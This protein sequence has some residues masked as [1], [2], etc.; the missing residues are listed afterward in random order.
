[1]YILNEYDKALKDILELGDDNP[2]RTGIVCRSLTGVQCSY[3]ISTHF[4]IPTKRRYAYKS[5]FAELLWMLSGSTNVN[6]LERMGSK[7]WSA[8]KD[9]EFEK[10]NGYND[11][12]LGPLYSFQMRHQGGDYNLRDSNP[13]GFDQIQYLVDELRN[14][15]HSRRIMMDLW[16][17]KDVCSDR[18]KLPPCHFNFYLNVDSKDRLTGILTQRSGDWLPGVSANIFFYSAFIY[19]LAQQSGLKPYKLIHNIHNAHIYLNQIEAVEEYLSREDRPSS[20]I[21]KLNKAKDIFSY[22]LDD[23][24]VEDYNPLDKI[25]VPVAL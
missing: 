24:V 9:K 1:M 13:G 8:W 19:M 2:T 25:K 6:D 16:N 4:P 15:K 23:F 18:V 11:G 10:R 21:L 20:P 12:E 3:D 17:A 22:A 14:N 5:I 7:I